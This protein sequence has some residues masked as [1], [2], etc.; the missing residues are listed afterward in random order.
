M[1][2]TVQQRLKIDLMTYGMSISPSAR[3]AL[4][5]NEGPRPLTLADYASTTGVALEI[6]E[7]IWVNAPISDFNPNFVTQPPLTLEKDEDRF[8]IRAGDLE[9]RV[10]PLPVPE[11]H[12]KRLP[13]GRLTT[14]FAITHTDRVRISPIQGCSFACTFCDLPYD[15]RYER[16]SLE[17]LVQSVRRAL[18]DKVLPAH[19]VL[20]S[21]GV[22]KEADWPWLNEVYENVSS[23]FP[24]T[25]VDVMMVPVPQHFHAYH[26][27]RIGINALSINLELFSEV[28]ARK[29]MP[30]KLRIGVE[31][32][33]KFIESAVALFGPGRVRSMLLVGLE[34]MED[35]LRGVQALA[36][37][38]C[39]PV[40]SPFRPDP[41]TPL[42]SQ[43]PPSSDLLQEVYLRS[44]EIV[45]RA[46]V[47][48][49]PRCIPCMHNTLTFPDDSGLYFRTQELL[50]AR[51]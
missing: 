51:V 3:H 49:G 39:D 33:L 18:D 25:H 13:S 28:A 15:K 1:D 41:A 22:P 2:L 42:K 9:F 7:D 17:G 43:P 26:L 30:R 24:G 31:T 37:R 47:K 32:F 36:E 46:G 21:G 35:T 14:D 45:E 12:D 19:H 27:H 34:P 5:G 48:L 20:I 23:S 29:I 6:E 10:N 11:Y 44:V 40:L 4:T 8:F 38:G 50:A 16:M